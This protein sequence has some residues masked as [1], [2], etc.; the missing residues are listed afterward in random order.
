MNY[1]DH[2]LRIRK[3][4]G[5]S[6]MTLQ[7]EI[8]CHKKLWNFLEVSGDEL[9]I[10]REQI[11]SYSE[12]LSELDLKPNTRRKLL[13]NLRSFYE[14]A[15][16]QGWIV[17]SPMNRIQLPSKREDPPKVLSVPQMKT[18]LALPDLNTA[19]G[20]RDRTIMELMYSSA[21]RRSEILTLKASSFFEN[22]RRVR[23][24]GKGN[25]EAVLPVGKLPAHF[26]KF[27]SEEVL[28]GFHHRKNDCLFIS[29]YSGDILKAKYLYQMIRDYGRQANFKIEI[30]PHVFRYS[31][32]THLAEEGVDV[33][34]IQE[35]L[36][37]ESPR[38]TTR[39]IEQGFKQLQSIHERTHPRSH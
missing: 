21:L 38:T 11:L 36:R 4:A 20:I 3:T 35:F 13:G 30:G 27:Y 8:E 34:F 2:Y 7:T 9:K 14:Y 37:H 24:L 28:K 32:A 39:Y 25:K 33:K 1:F 5:L 22:Y 31:I 19:L 26:L 15:V 18:L 23:V 29:V 16:R 10:T 17:L 12:Y 6:E